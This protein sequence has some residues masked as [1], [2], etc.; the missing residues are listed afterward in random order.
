MKNI[1]PARSLDGLGAGHRHDV[2][3]GKGCQTNGWGY[4]SYFAAAIAGVVF[5][6]TVLQVS[7]QAV[8]KRKSIFP[9]WGNDAW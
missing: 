5:Q 9:G 4:S 3:V 7:V 1:D 2:S 8:Q 6:Q